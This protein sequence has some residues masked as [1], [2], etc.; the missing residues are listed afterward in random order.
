MT[1]QGERAEVPEFGLLFPLRR[2][3]TE[4]SYLG[5][6]PRETTADRTAGGCASCPVQHHPAGRRRESP[7]PG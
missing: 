5:V 6:G 7:V 2:E 4:V 1:W 3:L